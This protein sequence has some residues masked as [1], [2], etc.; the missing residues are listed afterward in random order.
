VYGAGTPRFT[1][2]GTHTPRTRAQVKD[3]FTF[4]KPGFSRTT[5]SYSAASSGTTEY[6][7]V[8]SCCQDW[9]P[10]PPPPPPPAPLSPTPAHP[11]CK[12]PAV[13]PHLLPHV[14]PASSPAQERPKCQCNATQGYLERAKRKRS[15]RAKEQKSK[16]LA[17]RSKAVQVPGS[18]NDM[19]LLRRVTHS[20]VW[21]SGPRLSIFPGRK[22]GPLVGRRDINTRTRW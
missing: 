14:L 13:L 22:G 6:S 21:L 10:P 20:A 1:T 5:P 19:W 2:V 15:K 9:M 17:E 3:T 18:I 7:G 11:S 8:V 16:K 12:C 4:W